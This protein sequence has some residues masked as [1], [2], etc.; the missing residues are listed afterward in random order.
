MI[1]MPRCRPRSLPAGLAGACAALLLA[2]L[3]SCSRPAQ[4]PAPAPTPS[5]APVATA[6]AAG[7]VPL[8]ILSLI[9]VEHEADLLALRDGLVRR[10]LRD[11]GATV[12]RGELL[13][14]LDDADLQAQMD[15]A[16]ASIAIAENN[17]KYNQ[18]EL[19]AKQANHR[20]YKELLAQGLVSEA[21]YEKAEFEAKGAEYDLASWHSAVERAQAELR[22]YAAELERTRLRAPFAGVVARRY[23]REG[24]S[25]VKDDKCFRLSQLSPLL[26]RFLVPDGAARQP[27]VGDPVG[28]AI[29]S[30]SVQ[31]FR[32]V[33]RNVSPVVD[34]ASASLEVTAAL[35]GPGLERL[36]PGMGVRVLWA[37]LSA[38]KP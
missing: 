8:E 26:V 19:R 3:A 30:G 10:V 25:V 37:P 27:R 20:R 18:A 21:D 16:R 6:R 34:P 32:A 38:P 14:V 17:V 24:Q 11:Q 23:V 4:A 9:S 29:A 33:I 1:Q 7:A 22:K 15:Q 35:E 28:V 2:G 31:A 5:P 12:T 36:R 13:G